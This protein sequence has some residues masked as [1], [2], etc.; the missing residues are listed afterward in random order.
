ME[1]VHAQAL[2]SLTDVR[3]DLETAG[4]LN[5]DTDFVTWY[6]KRNVGHLMGKQE[7]FANELRPG[8]RH[9]LRVGDY[10]AAETPWRF[11]TIG[12]STEDLWFIGEDRT[13]TLT[14]S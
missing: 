2:D 12:I 4:V 6:L 7:S 3:G 10:G 13:F 1:D 5:Q 9:V 8:Y 14:L 11:G